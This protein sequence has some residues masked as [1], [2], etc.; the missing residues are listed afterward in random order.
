M[1]KSSTHVFLGTSLVSQKNLQDSNFC[2]SS[3]KSQVGISDGGDN[4]AERPVRDNK[5]LSYF[6]IKPSEES[7][8]TFLDGQKTSSFGSDPSSKDVGKIFDSPTTSERIPDSVPDQVEHTDKL[9]TIS[10]PVFHPAKF[11]LEN[12][13]IEILQNGEQLR[14][15]QIGIAI[16]KLHPN[17]EIDP[18]KIR[19]TLSQ[20]KRIFGMILDD[21]SSYTTNIV[22]WYLKKSAIENMKMPIMVNARGH[23]LSVAIPP[24][25]LHCLDAVTECLKNG[26]EMTLK[27]LIKKVNDNQAMNNARGFAL[28]SIHKIL[29]GS[30]RFEVARINHEG[31]SHRPKKV[32]RLKNQ[33]IRSTVI[34][35]IDYRHLSV[36]SA[37][38]ISYRAMIIPFLQNGEELTSKEIQA[39]VNEKFPN[40]EEEIHAWRSGISCELSRKE[41]IFERVLN[42]DGCVTPGG[43]WRMKKDAKAY[44]TS[45]IMVE[46]E[47]SK[48][49]NATPA[50]IQ[51]CLPLIASHEVEHKDDWE[52]MQ[53]ILDQAL[54]LQEDIQHRALPSGQ[55]TLNAEPILALQPEPPPVQFCSGIGFPLISQEY[56]VAT[57]FED[58]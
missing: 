39:K 41:G 7:S 38:R 23:C 6:Y 1:D 24:P 2:S 15:H 43:P 4:T 30:F 18:A 19:T 58:L 42:D 40:I 16:N 8:A 17:I 13:I 29:L 54:D 25:R 49:E 47:K 3:S 36:R 48:S 27:D 14:S 44:K 9:P 5:S 12:L 20:N 46:D 11:T 26:E 10:N 52:D 56:E 22:K 31:Y 21:D 50:I 35:C 37:G 53:S 33:T 34:D 51:P 45:V 32:W 57:E 55:A 28:S